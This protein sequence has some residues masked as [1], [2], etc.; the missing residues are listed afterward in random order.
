MKVWYSPG[1]VFFRVDRNTCAKF[2]VFVTSF[3]NNWSYM[4]IPLRAELKLAITNWAITV[5]CCAAAHYLLYS[6]TRATKCIAC[7]MDK[8]RI[9][10]ELYQ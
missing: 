4:F 1:G 8:C 7:L 5:D 6:E 3:A 10:T 2:A 9:F